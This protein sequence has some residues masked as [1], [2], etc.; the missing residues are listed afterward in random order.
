MT[1]PSA[2]VDEANR[3]AGRVYAAGHLVARVA[4]DRVDLAAGVHALHDADV[5]VEH[6]QIARLWCL[7]GGRRV[8]AA[9]ALRPR[10]QSVDGAEALALVAQRGARLPCR[11]RDEVG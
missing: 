8:G 4:L 1:V 10:V 11:P 9:G 3:V 2:D 5:L 7:P 6:D